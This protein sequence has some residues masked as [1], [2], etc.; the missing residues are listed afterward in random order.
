MFMIDRN[1][2]ENVKNTEVNLGIKKTRNNLKI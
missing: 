2:N 1:E